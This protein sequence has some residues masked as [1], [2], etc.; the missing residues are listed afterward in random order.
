MSDDI[1]KLALGCCSYELLWGL[2]KVEAHPNTEA[3]MKELRQRQLFFMRSCKYLM[4]HPSDKIREDAYLIMCDLLICF[5][6]VV[7]MLIVFDR[8]VE[9]Y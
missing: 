9:C 1:V 4:E 3:A 5:S 6:K 7:W 8:S 2:H